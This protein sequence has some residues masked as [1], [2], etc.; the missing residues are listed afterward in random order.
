MR[1]TIV[2]DDELLAK[3]QALTSLQE[4]SSLVKEALK[5]L[6]ERESA[7]RLANLGGTEPGLEAIP[8]RQTS[9]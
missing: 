7:K 4:K 1:T 8:R 9:A 6:I 3:A 5:A 2:L